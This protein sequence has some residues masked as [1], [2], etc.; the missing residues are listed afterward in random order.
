[1]EDVGIMAS[2]LLVSAFGIWL[3]VATIYFVLDGEQKA[4][5]EREHNVHTCYRLYTPEPP[6]GTQ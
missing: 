5:C 6:E 2:F 4:R 3:V 1:M